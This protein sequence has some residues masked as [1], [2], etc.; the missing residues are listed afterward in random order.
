M[1]AYTLLYVPYTGKHNSSTPQGPAIDERPILS[2]SVNSRGMLYL[3]VVV[4]LVSHRDF[5]DK[6][7][8]MTSLV[9][10]RSGVC[11][12]YDISTLWYAFYM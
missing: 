9:G 12:T 5:S 1:Q 10:I 3:Y 8:S 6:S 7:E 2:Q 4:I 11:M